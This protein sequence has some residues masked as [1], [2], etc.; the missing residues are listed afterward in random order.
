MTGKTAIE[1]A[2]AR[3]DVLSR[4]FYFG[5]REQRF[6]DLFSPFGTVARRGSLPPKPAAA[7]LELWNMAHD[8]EN[9]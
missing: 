5:L 7:S 1:W 9:V 3:R 8:S 2:T 6:I 4:L